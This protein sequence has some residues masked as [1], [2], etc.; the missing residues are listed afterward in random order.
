[1]N[2]L[3]KASI[4]VENMKSSVYTKIEAETALVKQSIQYQKMIMGSLSSRFETGAS[5]N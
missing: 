1:M 5:G 3:S 2:G 4:Q